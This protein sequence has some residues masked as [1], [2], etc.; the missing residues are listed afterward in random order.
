MKSNQMKLV[1][2]Y[3]LAASLLLLAV[4]CGK[5]ASENA[6]EE[7]IAS[8]SSETISEEMIAS[9]AAAKHPSIGYF[10]TERDSVVCEI[11]VEQNKD[12]IESMAREAEAAASR[13]ADATKEATKA[14]ADADAYYASKED[15][16][17]VPVAGTS[18]SSLQ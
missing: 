13:A 6:V 4:S 1:V 17:K 11:T 12:A 5:P 2:C 14:I 18:S 7:G 8:I 9:I 15:V 10:N 16:E 3:A